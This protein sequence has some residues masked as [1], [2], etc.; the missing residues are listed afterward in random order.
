[1]FSKKPEIIQAM[2]N[3][4]NIDSYYESTED[5]EDLVTESSKD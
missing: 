4:I 2:D 5:N 1:L 3:E